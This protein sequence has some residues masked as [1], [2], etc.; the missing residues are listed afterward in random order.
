[1][2]DIIV[3]QL[4]SGWTVRHERI[5]FERFKDRAAAVRRAG[6]LRV[7]LPVHGERPALR[8]VDLRAI[9]RSAKAG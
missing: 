5:L 8:V 7:R 1:M 6:N 9:D 2:S 3:Q 4:A